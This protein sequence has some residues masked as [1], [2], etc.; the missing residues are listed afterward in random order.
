MIP[1]P[2]KPPLPAALGAERLLQR[3]GLR[4][5]GRPL[6]AERGA[7]V[8]ERALKACLSFHF[9]FTTHRGSAGGGGEE[10]WGRHQTPAG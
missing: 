6:K 1:L 4:T 2:R 3:S 7:E 5:Y 8:R 9:Y 10:S